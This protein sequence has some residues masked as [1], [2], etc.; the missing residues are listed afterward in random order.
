MSTINAV[1]NQHV[2]SSVGCGKTA[3]MACPTCLKL[4]I[5]PSRFCS[6]ECFKTG[7]NEHKMLHSEVKKARNAVDPTSIPN[8]F[9]DFK[10]TGSVRPCQKSPRRT[11]PDHIPRP[12]YATH[13]NGFP[14]DE[15]DEKR[16]SSN[17]IRVYTPTEIAGIREVCRIGR[18]ILD[19]AGLAVKVGITT[20]EI[21]RIVHEATVEREA[22]PSPLNYH[23]FPKSLCTSVNEIVCHG[24]PDMRPL[25]EGDIVNLD[26]SVFK[27]G[28][29]AD[30]NET[31]MVGQ[32]DEQSYNLVKCSYESLAAAV[33]MVRPGTMYR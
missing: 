16:N 1:D 21:D 12:G 15:Q 6:Q 5:P 9:R 26:I 13:P 14:Q 20:D 8:E 25:C 17:V 10:F 30:L 31:F 18:E 19:I 3:I 32:V 11:V 23:M 4:G 24:I 28:F 7:W 29:H 2:C 33:A 22:Y 27:G